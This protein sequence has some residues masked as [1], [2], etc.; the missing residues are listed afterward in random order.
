MNYLLTE[1]ELLTVFKLVNN[2][3]DPEGVF[4]FDMKTRH[5]YKDVLGEQTE[6]DNEEEASYI[7]ENYF[8]EETDINEYALTIFERQENGLYEKSEEF[9]RQKAYS[10]A[11]VEALAKQAG[12]VFEAVMDESGGA[13]REDSERLIYILREKGKKKDNE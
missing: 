13:P 4:V 10:S 7:W 9:H 6:A 8:D 11:C 1:E 2:Y 5:F 3:L 12:M